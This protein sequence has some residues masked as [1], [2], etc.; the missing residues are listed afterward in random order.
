MV[1]PGG[2]QKKKDKALLGFLSWTFTYR[3]AQQL[4]KENLKAIWK[5]NKTNAPTLSYC[6]SILIFHDA[7]RSLG[8]WKL[9]ARTVQ[10]NLFLTAHMINS[11]Q[12]GLMSLVIVQWNIRCVYTYTRIH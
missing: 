3:S 5:E 10:Y 9:I 12:R 7:R 1:V 8:L 11:M 4:I 6:L 2:G